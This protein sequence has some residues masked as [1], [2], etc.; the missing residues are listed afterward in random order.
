MA[1]RI[2][3]TVRKMTI[4]PNDSCDFVTGTVTGVNPITIS[5]NGQQYSS[6]FLVLSPFCIR[7]SVNLGHSH[8]CPDG[9]TSTELELVLLW[10][11]LQVGD[12]V[13]MIKCNGG[14]KFYVL[15]RK[16]GVMI[17]G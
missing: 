5:Y 1:A 3:N 11:G 9:G 12:I 15:Q 7:T 6:S 17:E 14:Q 8:T 2:T 4:T 10:R 16:E 13:Y